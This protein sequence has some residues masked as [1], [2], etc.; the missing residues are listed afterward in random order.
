MTTAI[1]AYQ[2][3]QSKS[4]FFDISAFEDGQRMATLLAKSKLIP[5]T[6]QGNLPDCLI[7]LEL[8]M[9][10]GVSPMAVMQNTFIIHGRPGY[11]AQFVIAMINSSGKYSPLRFELTGQGENRSCMAWAYELSSGDKLE[12]TPVSLQM[13]KD[14][15]WMGK[16]GS[17]W[18]TMPELMLRYRAAAFFGRMYAPELLMGMRTAEELHDEPVASSV[19]SSPTMMSTSDLNA[20]FSAPAENHG[21]EVIIEVPSDE[22]IEVNIQ[23]ATSSPVEANPDPVPAQAADP[24]KKTAQ[25][26]K[27][28]AQ[29]QTV[30][31]A[32]SAVTETASP[33]IPIE[34]NDSVSKLVAEL[35]R[36]LTW[37]EVMRW[38]TSRANALKA[39]NAYDRG[40]VMAYSTF[41]LHRLQ[42]DE[43]KTA[44]GVNEWA[45]LKMKGIKVQLE[46]HCPAE[47][48]RYFGYLQQHCLD[49]IAELRAAD[50]NNETPVMP[51]EPSEYAE[52]LPG[53]DPARTKR[54]N[55]FMG[56]I[57]EKTNSLQLNSWA[58]ATVNAR[59]ALVEEE[60]ELLNEKL[61][62]RL[63][64]LEMSE[65]TRK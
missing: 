33:Q 42:V 46:K 34:N 58:M 57:D 63:A 36:L 4:V 62:G 59:M 6:F 3:P 18:Q 32:V 22:I 13:A 30:A 1:Q 40:W 65:G 21:K 20:R 61:L 2:P 23:E 51:D 64:E 52:P 56:Q 19:Q 45:D 17:K 8:A 16:A 48:E 49:K 54:F 37:P 12:G 9:R 28:A 26:K 11:S 29:P 5:T 10:I 38:E 35:D 53:K 27:A 44:D 55:T 41:I 7:A 50:P 14:E 24:V 39:L 60:Q 15:G 25:K 43:C 47:A 31:E